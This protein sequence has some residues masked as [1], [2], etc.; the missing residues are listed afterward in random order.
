MRAFIQRECFIKM[1]NTVAH[2]SSNNN[3]VIKVIVVISPA[4]LNNKFPKA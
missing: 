3:S 1:T 2:I 4:F